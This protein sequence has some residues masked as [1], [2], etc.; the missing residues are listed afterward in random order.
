MGEWTKG[1]WL[2]VDEDF[3]YALNEDGTNR[4]D[5][6]VNGGYVKYDRIYRD[7]N[8]RTSEEEVAANTALIAAA[9]EL[10]EALDHAKHLLEE[11]APGC[12][13]H[14]IMAIKAALAKAEGR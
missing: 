6:R 4:F 2:T 7:R 11:Y 13:K 3:V 14:F 5:C 10:Y 1:P 9:P 8:V 12:P